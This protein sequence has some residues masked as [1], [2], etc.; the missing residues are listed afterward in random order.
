MYWR[1]VNDITCFFSE[2]WDS[3]KLELRDQSP[4]EEVFP[5]LGPQLRHQVCLGKQNG[6]KTHNLLMFKV[7]DP[8]GSSTWFRGL[9][10]C[11]QELVGSSPSVSRATSLTLNPQLLQ[12]LTDSAF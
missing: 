10:C 11:D 2:P 9:G 6:I 7:W 4:K 5:S 12:R 3:R 1:G 8:Y